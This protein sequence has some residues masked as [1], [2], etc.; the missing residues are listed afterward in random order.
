[1]AVFNQVEFDNHEQVVFCSDEAS[2][3]KAII[4]VHNTKLGPA[5][6]GCRLWNYASD[7]DAVYD[8]LRLSKGMTYK[9]AVARLPFG[10][11]KSVIIGDAKTIKSEALFRAFGKHLDRLGGSYYS[12][13][14]V[15]I[16]T[17]DVMV[18]HKETNY[19]MGLEGKSGN[20]SPYT[21][22]GTFLG[23]KAAYQHK[24]GHQDL[25]GIKVAVQG[26]G[27]VAYTLCKHLHEAG[28]ELFVTDINEESVQ[29]VVNDFNATAV[30]IDEIYDL[31]VDV[32]APCALGATVND[33]TI[34]RIKA[35]IIAGCANNQ[36]A[37]SRHG[38]IIRE[39]GVLYAPDYVIN[40]GG[41]INVY[42]ETKPE[43]YDEAAATKHVEGIYDTL[44]EIFKRSED[45]KV[46]T[47]IIADKLAQEIIE[48]GL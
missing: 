8:V 17:G 10:G 27:A 14:D 3:L 33:D 21:A 43:G 9:N 26:L 44:T 22:L 45:E 20:P 35:T 36:L 47:H 32:Y 42:Y 23:I 48:N 24:Y 30:G 1:M 39:K 2:G 34:P 28:A 15:N 4:A 16:T 19:V 37:E 40:A 38:E 41:I 5:V 6:G 29:R 31:D 46:S 7:E 13:E 11:G 12:A 25:A 18:M